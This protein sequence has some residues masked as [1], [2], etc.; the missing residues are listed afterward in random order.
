M[1][2]YGY[3]R[4]TGDYDA[5]EDDPIWDEFDEAMDAFVEEITSSVEVETVYSWDKVS[6]SLGELLGEDLDPHLS[7]GQYLV[8]LSQLAKP[9]ARRDAAHRPRG[10]RRSVLLSVPDNFVAFNLG[11]F[12][13]RDLHAET[14][15]E[16][17][18]AAVEETKNLYLHDLQTAFDNHFDRENWGSAEEVVQDFRDSLDDA[19]NSYQVKSN[20][21]GALSLMPVSELGA[22]EYFDL[23]GIAD[24]VVW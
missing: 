7:E 9:R 18:D 1:A 24:Y 5:P 17:F 19:T 16:L 3:D 4:G 14:V 22:R 23:E 10:T 21:F 11:K 12:G 8:Q 2:F 6:L 20:S 13:D 15:E